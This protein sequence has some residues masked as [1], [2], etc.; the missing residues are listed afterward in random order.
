MGKTDRDPGR[1]LK[2][3]LTN[4]LERSNRSALYLWI[5]EVFR[6][7]HLVEMHVIQED[8]TPKEL[9]MFEILL[10]ELVPQFA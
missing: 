9:D 5:Q 7:G 6:T 4:A 1:R 8:V 2:Q 10:D 3:H